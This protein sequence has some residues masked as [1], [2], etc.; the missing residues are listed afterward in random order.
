MLGGGH[1]VQDFGFFGLFGFSQWFFGLLLG[2]LWFLWFFWFCHVF[3]GLFILL[4]RSLI[5]ILLFW[6]LIPLLFLL[7]ILLF[8]FRLFTPHCNSLENSYGLR[9]VRAYTIPRPPDIYIYIY[10]ILW[11]YITYVAGDVGHTVVDQHESA[12][13]AF[14]VIAVSIVCARLWHIDSLCKVVI[15]R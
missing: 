2:L 10:I 1:G 14:A 15:Y 6:I 8:L 9:G 5:L 3:F 13:V 12:V 4:L 11:V 7:T